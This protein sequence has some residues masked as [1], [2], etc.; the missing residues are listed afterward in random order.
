MRKDNTPLEGE[1]EPASSKQV[2]LMR[3]EERRAGQLEIE[4]SNSKMRRPVTVGRGKKEWFNKQ[5]GG[6]LRRKPIARDYIQAI[7]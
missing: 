6:W 7:P 1:G 4:Y 5:E 2:H 3:K